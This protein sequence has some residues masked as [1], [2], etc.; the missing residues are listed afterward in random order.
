MTDIKLQ[1]IFNR[2]KD[3]EFIQDNPAYKNTAEKIKIKL[4]DS[5]IV[6]AYATTLES[7]S[8]VIAVNK[9]LCYFCDAIGIALALGGKEILKSLMMEYTSI[10]LS[11]KGKFRDDDLEECIESIEP[12]P[13]EFIFKE[14]TSYSDACLFAILGHELGHICLSH[15]IHGENSYND[16]ISRNNER[17]ADLFTSSVVMSSPFGKYII[18]GNLLFLIG[19]TWITNSLDCEH[20]ATSH[21]YSRERAEYTF[22]SHEQDLIAYGITRES[23]DA[24]MPPYACKSEK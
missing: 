6:N 7:G 22:N 2:V 16:S 14:A 4:I 19:F 1:S 11:K 20:A 5:N 15:T 3:S 13:T 21:P 23:F 12:K 9:G 8:H 24:M 18:T 10:I 17:S